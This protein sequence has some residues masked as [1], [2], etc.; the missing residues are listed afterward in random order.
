[1]A[2]EGAVG[3]IVLVIP[4]FD[5]SLMSRNSVNEGLLALLAQHQSVPEEM[6]VMLRGIDAA[7][8]AASFGIS[9]PVVSKMSAG[10]PC[11]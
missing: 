10:A 11:L 2:V 5:C 3:I 9:R 8:V 1:M 4:H 6:L 7:V